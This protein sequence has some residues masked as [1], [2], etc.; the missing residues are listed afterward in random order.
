MPGAPEDEE[1]EVL[2]GD[3][4]VVVQGIVHDHGVVHG[5]DHSV[6]LGVVTGDVHV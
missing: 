4:V 1:V 5:V 2:D 6:D 3:D